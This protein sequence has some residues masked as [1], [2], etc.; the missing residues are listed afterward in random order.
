MLYL[1][2]LSPE[3]IETE[4]ETFDVEVFVTF[5]D[6]LSVTFIISFH[7]IPTA[8]INTCARVPHIIFFGRKIIFTLA[9][10]LIIIPF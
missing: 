3:F 9:L 8:D 7:K 10:T 2:F 4:L 6:T 5:V 1:S